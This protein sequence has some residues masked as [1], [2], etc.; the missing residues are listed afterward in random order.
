M[1]V[2]RESVIVDNDDSR[3]KNKAYHLQPEDIETK[4][5]LKKADIRAYKQL[6]KDHWKEV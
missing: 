6:R 2:L 5:T 4:E 1:K 3:A